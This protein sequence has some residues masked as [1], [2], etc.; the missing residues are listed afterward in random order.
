VYYMQVTVPKP[1]PEATLKRRVVTR[2]SVIAECMQPPVLVAG[3]ASLLESRRTDVTWK[4]VT[5]WVMRDLH[6]EAIAQLAAA[7][8]SGEEFPILAPSTN[9]ADRKAFKIDAKLRNAVVEIASA[10][11]VSL[12]AVYYT[13]F[14]KYLVAQGVLERAW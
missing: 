13:A 2:P 14:R 3:Y 8:H 4:K 9:Q 6:E 10:R 12:G 5:P 7:F 11:T 1:L